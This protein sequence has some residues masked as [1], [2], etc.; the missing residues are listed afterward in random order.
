[1]GSVVLFDAPRMQAIEDGTVTSGLVDVSGHL[2]LT[3]HDG[4]TVDAG[5]VT[6]PNLADASETVKGIARVATPTEVIAGTDDTIIVSPSGLQNLTATT[7]RNGIARL[8]TSAEALAGTDATKAVT[9]STLSAVF[10]AQGKSMLATVDPTWNGL[11]N[12]PITL[13]DTT[14]TTAKLPRGLSSYISAGSLVKVRSISGVWYIDDVYQD[15]VVYPR[16]FDLRSA[17]TTAGKGV[18]YNDVV[19]SDG[20][21]YAPPQGWRL[22]SGECLLFGLI[23]PLATWNNNDVILT[24]PREMW[25]LT[26]KIFFTS[27][28]SVVQRI[29]VNTDGTV[30]VSGGQLSSNYSSLDG[31]RWNNSPSLTRTTMVLNAAASWVNYGTPYGSATYVPDDG[32]GRR[33]YA[34]VIK[35]GAPNTEIATLAANPNML[36]AAGGKAHLIG[37]PDTNGYSRFDILPANAG[38]YRAAAPSG[39]N[40]S[41][42]FSIDSA[43]LT[44]AY[45]AA[46]TDVYF[47]N[48]GSNYDTT[49]WASC[50]I[51]RMGDGAVKMTGLGV[52]T[53]GGTWLRVPQSMA[54]KHYLIF[55]VD[56]T[57]GNARVDVSPTGVVFFQAG[58][59]TFLS[60]ESLQ[61]MPADAWDRAWARL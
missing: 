23:R 17:L 49:N 9:P 61:W 31:I 36:A 58:T 50:R 33:L 57:D 6:A 14:V 41:T 22:T 26:N 7:G 30:T 15:T 37:Q 4:S 25:P 42:Q 52:A 1:M 45:Y 2:I 29:F 38:L 24:L 39:T 8:A 46:A 40:P 16:L 19:S 21:L 32:Y 12:A 54:P 11:G 3:H 56:G 20:N 34:G 55:F 35:G 48:G 18:M 28:N 59:G 53:A 60:L 47:T 5:K 10:I 43:I 44:E 27:Y 13:S 51:S